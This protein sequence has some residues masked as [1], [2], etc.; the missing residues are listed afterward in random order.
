M[1]K[2]PLAL[3]V[4]LLVA[5]FSTSFAQT[6]GYIG[7]FGDLAGTQCCITGLTST[8]VYIYAV[9]GGQTAGGTGIG[10]AEFRVEIPS[11][12]AA[13][14]LG[15]INNPNAAATVALGNPFEDASDTGDDAA[16]G[17]GCNISFPTAQ[18]AAAG[19]KILL[20]S[21]LIFSGAALSTDMTV[22]SKISPSNP[23]NGDCPLMV[24]FDPPDFTAVC[25]TPSN[26][27]LGEQAILFRSYVRPNPSNCPSNGTTCGPV[28]VAQSTWSAMKD[29]YR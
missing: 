6:D 27:S 13:S 10:G 19:D 4:A 7:V 16:N 3:A 14:I 15:I 21:P 23:L 2:S 8:T 18:G 25:L 22:K 26:A 9:L 5:T 24:L 17:G 11:K 20:Y 1:R 29:L 12:A 28:A